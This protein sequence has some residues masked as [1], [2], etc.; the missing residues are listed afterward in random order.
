MISKDQAHKS[1]LEMS[2]FLIL[3]LKIFNRNKPQVK[4]TSPLQVLDIQISYLIS[5]ECLRLDF[6]VAVFGTFP[7]FGF[8]FKTKTNLAINVRIRR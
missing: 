8:G 5:K 1:R 3:T 6:V 7:L 2:D 4:V